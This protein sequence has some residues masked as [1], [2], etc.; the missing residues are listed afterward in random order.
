[1]L[2]FVPLSARLDSQTTAFDDDHRIASVLLVYYTVILIGFGGIW[3][4][5][6]HT[7]LADD[8]AA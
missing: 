4:F 1:M 5:V 2:I 8:I 3:S 6:G 7:F